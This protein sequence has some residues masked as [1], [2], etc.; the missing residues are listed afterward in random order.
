MTAIPLH[1]LFSKAEAAAVKVSPNAKYLAWMARTNGGAL[2]LFC[3][4]LPLRPPS[5]INSGIPGGRQLTACQ[6]RDIC[7][8]FT[9]TRDDSRILYLRETE[10]GSE[11]YHLY[12]IDIEQTQAPLSGGGIDLLAAHPKVT[13]C[14]GFVGGLQ[15]WLPRSDPNIAIIS[16]GRGSLLWDLSELNLASGSLRTVAANPAS[17]WLG[18]ARLLAALLLHIILVVVCRVLEMITLGLATPVLRAVQY[19]APPPAAPVQYFVDRSGTLIGIASAALGLPSGEKSRVPWP[20]GVALRFTKRLRRGGFAPVCADIPF[21]DLN[22]QLVG[23]G[24]A[25]GRLRLVRVGEGDAVAIHTCDTADTTAYVRFDSSE[26]PPAILAQSPRADI[27]GFYDSPLSGE[28]EAIVVTAQRSEVVPLSEGGRR[29][30]AELAR[31]RAAIDDANTAGGADETLELS[32]ASRSLADDVWV[33]RSQSDTAPAT[34]WLLAPYTSGSPRELLCAR[35]ALRGLSAALS[36]MAAV[37]IPARDGEQLPGYL[38]LPR[39]HQRLWSAG[40]SDASSTPPPPPLVLCIHGGPNERDYAGFDPW[41]QLLA[42]RGMAV[43]S[44]DYRGS[45][46]YGRRFCNLAHGNVRGMH[47]DVEDA[48]RWAVATGLAAPH[49]IAILGASWGGYLALGGAT[50]VAA[51]TTASDDDAA[52]SPRYAAV[53]AI[54]PLVAVGAANTSPAFRSDPLVAQYWRQ[55]YGPSVAKDVK[56]AAALS[57]LHRLE[58][59]DKAVKLLLVHGERDPRVPREHGDAVAAAAMRAGLAGAHLTY[60]REGHAIRREPNVLHMWHAIERFLC[61][62]FALPAPPAV[63]ARLFQGN[64]CTVQWDSVGVYGMCEEEKADAE[65]TLAYLAWRHPRLASYDPPPSGTVSSSASSSPPTKAPRVDALVVHGNSMVACPLGAADLFVDVL[66]PAGCRAV[67]LTGGVGRETPPLWL[68]LASRGLK[69]LFSSE[70]GGGSAP[71]WSN[72]RPPAHVALPAQGISSKPVL[73][74]FDLTLAPE[75]LRAYASEADVFLELF[76][77]RCRERGLG[78]CVAFGG[79]PMADGK[80]DTATASRRRDGGTAYVYLE[81]A[82]THTGTNVEFSR[83]TLR[84]LGLDDQTAAVA[85]VQQP[86]L[87]LRTCLTWQKQTGR[88]PLGWTVRPTEAAVGRSFAEQLRYALGEVRRIPAYAKADKAFCVMPDDFPH[89]AA[90]RLEELEPTIQAALDLEVAA[91]ARGSAAAKA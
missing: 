7:F 22:M 37:S 50:E 5:N 10:H 4:S 54:V 24:A 76:L 82:S 71:P 56:A 74:G 11:L 78:D 34:F 41:V 77:S 45:T 89:E 85:V 43:L 59:L 21:S 61:D 70:H 86:Q 65:K 80:D 20:P 83:A 63:E 6:S 84:V 28:L 44:V 91:K 23:S 32:I 60:A 31:V 29:L 19:L 38:T 69:P 30:Q 88:Q 81:T 47:E 35:P 2:N 62:A 1:T 87:H 64:T 39:A 12:A 66:Y 25:S 8:Y 17:T 68:E 49:R 3:A 79:N 27:S 13:C 57:P 36:P 15:L 46:G 90:R 42:A 73:D 67:I 40:A 52:A 48:R 58:N 53:V 16:T 51:A 14:V 75:A 55:L 9:F 18:I 26:A 33:V 72:D